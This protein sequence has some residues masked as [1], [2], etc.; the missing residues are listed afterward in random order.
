[1]AERVLEAAP[2]VVPER[3]VPAQ[4][5]MHLAGTIGN[6]QAAAGA[7]RREGA[8]DLARH[9]LERAGDLGEVAEIGAVPLALNC[10][11]FWMTILP[12]MATAEPVLLAVSVPET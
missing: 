2:R 3:D 12:G 10:P 9:P 1:M 4:I 7:D 6:R 8:A 5:G 11:P